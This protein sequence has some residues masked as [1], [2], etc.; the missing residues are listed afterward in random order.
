[1]EIWRNDL[2]D[3]LKGVERFVKEIDKVKDIVI[4]G[5]INPDGDC[6]GSITGLGGYLSECCN[7]RVT[8]IVPNAIPGYLSFLLNDLVLYTFDSQRDLSESA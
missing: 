6:I 7:K 3:N 1:M 8:L 2:Q 5:H 4:I